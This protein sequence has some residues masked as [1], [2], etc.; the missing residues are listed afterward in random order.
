MVFIRT[1]KP[2]KFFN[3]SNEKALHL[4]EACNAVEFDII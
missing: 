3:F 1:Q 2:Q 4:A